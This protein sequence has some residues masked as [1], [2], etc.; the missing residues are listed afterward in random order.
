LLPTF[1]FIKSEKILTSTTSGIK[2]IDN[3]FL[4]KKIAYHKKEAII[5]KK[6]I[7]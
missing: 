2:Y 4:I 6:K 5:D 3:L 1:L 7:I